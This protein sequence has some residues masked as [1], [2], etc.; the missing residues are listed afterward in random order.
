MG[1][2]VPLLPTSSA[3]SSRSIAAPWA[4]NQQQPQC[5]TAE[6]RGGMNTGV[7]PWR[8]HTRT[9]SPIPFGDTNGPPLSNCR[10][11][12]TPVAGPQ[13]V[14]RRQHGPVAALLDDLDPGVMGGDVDLV[15]RVEAHPA[16]KMPRPDQI[17]LHHL[18]GSACRWRRVR[19]PLARPTAGTLA[20]GRASTLEDLLDRTLGRHNRTELR[21][22]PGDRRR[23]DLRPRVLL[24]PRAHL[25][26]DRLDPLVGTTRHPL[27]RARATSAQHGSCGS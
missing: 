14:Q 16:V 4:T 18:T 2:T 5:A 8:R 12:G 9:T 15:Q 26:H 19:D 3:S 11:S 7:T 24:Q 13:R 27:G 17:D 23:A 25:Q 22:L 20:L 21:K 1:R 10:R 6:S